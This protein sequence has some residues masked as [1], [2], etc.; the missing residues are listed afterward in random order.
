MGMEVSDVFY[1]TGTIT[2][3]TITALLAFLVYQ[4]YVTLRALQE[5]MTQAHNIA[6]NLKSVSTGMQFGFWALL[7]KL[8][9]GV[10]SG[11]R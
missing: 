9:G 4:I 10:I 1:A 6:G 7:T 3:I 11:R 8:F 5:A 2:L